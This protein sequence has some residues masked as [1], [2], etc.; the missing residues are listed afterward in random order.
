LLLFKSKAHL[1][2]PLESLID[3]DSDLDWLVLGR[4]HG[5]PTRLLDWTYSPYVAAW[6][7]AAEGAES[8]GTVW[9]TSVH[10]INLSDDNSALIYGTSANLLKIVDQTTGEDVPILFFV[11]RVHNQR[12]ALQ[13]GLFS[14]AGD[15]LMDQDPLL[16][17]VLSKPDWKEVETHLRIEIPATEKRGF[18]RRL[19]AMNITGETL[20]GD[21]DGFCNELLQILRDHPKELGERLEFATQHSRATRL[22]RKG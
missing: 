18:I 15:A 9:C 10:H 5:L 22:P 8:G 6:I 13:Q 20:S 2:T 17:D 19:R 11:P 16:A 21:L 7:A 4:H 12:S 14:I 1:Y 3:G